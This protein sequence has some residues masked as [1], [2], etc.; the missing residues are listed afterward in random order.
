MVQLGSTPENNFTSTQFK[1]WN[2]NIQGVCDLLVADQYACISAPGGTYIS[3]P[4]SN[5]S[6]GNAGQQRGGGDGSGTAT[7]SGSVAGGGRNSTTVTVGGAAPSP[8]QSGITPLCTEYAEAQAGDGCFSLS[9]LWQIT[10]ADLYTWNTVLGPD[11]ANCSTQLFA[12]FWYCIAI[13]GSTTTSSSPSSTSTAPSVPSPVQSGI[14]P[15][16]TSYAE[17]VSGDF[18]SEFASANGITTGQLYLWNPIL[19]ANGANCATEFQANTYY[20]VGAPSATATTTTSA[21]S[22]TTSASTIPSPTQSGIIS[23]CNKYAEAVSGDF[24]S[25][26]AP[27]NDMSTDQLYAWN[28]ILG[29]N[30]ANCNMEFQ[31]NTY[32]CVGVSS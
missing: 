27:A 18:C 12:D 29:A 1:T 28:T 32:Y 31:A 10:E 26:F 23:S 9:S 5:S 20:C 19:G 11:G 13:Q 14:N 2:P 6:S 4:A 22:T 21:S 8:T 30:G 3:P 15:Q 25:E 7:G 24:C 17:A 16:C